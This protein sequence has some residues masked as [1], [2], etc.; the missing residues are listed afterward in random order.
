MLKL[1][2]WWHNIVCLM[3]VAQSTVEINSCHLIICNI[4]SSHQYVFSLDGEE[5]FHLCNSAFMGGV[6][7]HCHSSVLCW[8]YPSACMCPSHFTTVLCNMAVTQFRCWLPG[9]E[10]WKVCPILI[11]IACNN[12]AKDDWYGFTELIIAST[13]VLDI[14][15]TKFFIGALVTK[16]TWPLSQDWYVF[17]ATRTYIHFS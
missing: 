7:I 10:M 6:C 17:L 5:N 13:I 2:K 8:H 9:C 4:L 12:M 16:K 15:L 11:W 3:A 14:R 1:L